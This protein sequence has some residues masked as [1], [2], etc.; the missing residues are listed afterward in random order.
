MGQRLRGRSWSGR[1][2]SYASLK[3]CNGRGQIGHLCQ[4]FVLL[5]V[6]KLETIENSF[7]HR[8]HDY[9]AVGHG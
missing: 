8:A 4:D 6:E 9:T 3:L 1:R 7:E 5:V 2:R